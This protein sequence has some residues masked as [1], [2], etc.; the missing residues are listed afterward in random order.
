M[1][2]S[3]QSSTVLGTWPT[4]PDDV[5]AT[6]H[7]ETGTQSRRHA[8]GRAHAGACSRRTQQVARTITSPPQDT[9]TGPTRAAM[10]QLQ[11]NNLIVEKAPYLPTLN[12]RRHAHSPLE[13]L[14]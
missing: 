6:S 4:A 7:I 1:S 14:P 5:T 9:P 10:L 11:A 8:I 2:T 13:L 3:S 12:G